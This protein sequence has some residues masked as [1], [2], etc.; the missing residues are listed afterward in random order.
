M[1]ETEAVD[2]ANFFVP[3]KAPAVSSAEKSKAVDFNTSTSGTAEL[4]IQARS[5]QRIDA[6]VAYGRQSKWNRC[7][8]VHKLAF[9]FVRGRFQM[10]KPTFFERFASFL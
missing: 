8:A 10:E 5:S 3:G 1:K 4:K 7:F 9:H 6:D 2:S